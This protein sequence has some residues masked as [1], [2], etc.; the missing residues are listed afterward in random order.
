MIAEKREKRLRGPWI[1]GYEA[2]AEY[3]GL[4][5]T[6]LRQL[7]SAGRLSAVRKVGRRVL[8]SLPALDQWINA[9]EEGA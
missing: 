3:T 6:Y 4:S 7:V 8:F 1:S 2:A 9:R 5:S